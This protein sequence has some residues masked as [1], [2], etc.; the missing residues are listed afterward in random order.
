VTLFPYTTLFRSLV[1]DPNTKA[2]DILY[3][4]ILSSYCKQ[5]FWGKGTY[6]YM[7]RGDAST[8]NAQE[9]TIYRVNMGVNGSPVK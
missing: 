1:I 7:M 8:T 3:K 6:L 5:I 2:V 9:W 4:G